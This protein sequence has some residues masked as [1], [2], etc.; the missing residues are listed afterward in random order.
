MDDVAGDEED[1]ENTDSDD[2]EE[3]NMHKINIEERHLSHL[4]TSVSL[5]RA[6]TMR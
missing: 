6:E 4:T 2:N 3:L 5:L 1:H